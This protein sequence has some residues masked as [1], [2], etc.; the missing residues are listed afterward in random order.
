V[1]VTA[2]ITVSD[3]GSSTG[4][5]KEELNIPAVGDVGKVIMAMAHADQEM[6]DLLGYRFSHGSLE[7]HPVRNIL[8]AALIDLQGNLTE[9]TQ[10]LSRIL[11]VNGTI[12]PLTEEK[13]ELVGVAGDKEFYGEEEVS[14]NVRRIHRL[15]YDHDITVRKEITDKIRGADLIILPPGSLYT[16]IIPHLLSEDV[17]EAIR[18]SPAPV[19][20]VANL[21]TQPGE[22]DDPRL[23]HHI[24]V[25]NRFL[26]YRKVNVCLANNSPLDPSVA[27]RYLDTEGKRML[28]V[29]RDK[30]EA[31]GCR[32]L[33][34]DL[35]ELD[36]EEKVRHHPV[37]TGYLV[38]SYI[39]KVLE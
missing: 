39:M 7:N 19:M 31:M 17:L 6:V 8:L 24:R 35:F 36:E 37:K 9:A 4:T 29:D 3:N 16:S 5:L 20:Y 10:Y 26:K 14:E 23:S 25:L 11:R 15:T 30:V 38:F 27:Q 34:G 32:V 28:L 18:Y 13:V 33:S 21:V 2:I 22:T 12:Y 1:D